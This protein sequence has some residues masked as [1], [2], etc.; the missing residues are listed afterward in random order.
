MKKK[1]VIGACAAA[2]LALTAACGGNDDPG[3]TAPSTGESTPPAGASEAKHNAADV[4]FAQGM[5]P[6]HEQAVD[7]AEMAL[8]RSSDSAMV[9][10]AERIKSAQAPE[11]QQ[12][13]SM[14]SRWDAPASPTM[15]DMPDMDHGSMSGMMTEGEMQKLEQAEGSEFDRLW[16]QLMTK[17][18]RGAVQMAEKELAE[19]HNAEAKALARR[20]IDAQQAEIK[21]MQDLLK[22]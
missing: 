17:H 3:A 15:G 14:L 6:H 21:E 2:V 9:D 5:I 18:H 8:Q 22:R 19:G 4:A 12:L 16:L 13:S 11:I 7:M 20:I 10:L 1:Y